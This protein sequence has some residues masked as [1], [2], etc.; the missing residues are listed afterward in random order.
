MTMMTTRLQRPMPADRGRPA[1][2]GMAFCGMCGGEFLRCGVQGGVCAACW[3]EEYRR[4][5]EAAAERRSECERT[6][7]ELE[8]MQP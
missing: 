5:E 1:R 2:A 8:Q 3:R 4:A 6:M 7:L